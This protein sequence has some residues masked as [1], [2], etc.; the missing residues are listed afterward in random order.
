V[1]SLVFTLAS[2][3]GNDAAT[4]LADLT[5][6]DHNRAVGHL[7]QITRLAFGNCPFSCKSPGS[8]LRIERFDAITM[9]HQAR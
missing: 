6:A 4:A 8:N 2:T 1:T 3:P 7:S 9:R 5:A